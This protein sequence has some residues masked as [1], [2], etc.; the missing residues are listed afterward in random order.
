MRCSIGGIGVLRKSA[1]LVS[2]DAGR[3]AKAGQ[4][5]TY[6]LKCTLRLDR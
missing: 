3:L 2:G 5:D 4:V 1:H 6:R